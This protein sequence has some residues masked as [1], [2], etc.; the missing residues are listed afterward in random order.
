MSAKDIIFPFSKDV[1]FVGYTPDTPVIYRVSS[2][3]ELAT[4]L[5]R[6]KEETRHTPVNETYLIYASFQGKKI[7]FR[8]EGGHVHPFDIENQSLQELDKLS[9]QEISIPLSEFIHTV[10]RSNQDGYDSGITQG[11]GNSKPE[12]PTSEAPFLE[13]AKYIFNEFRK[14][15]VSKI[16]RE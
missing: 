5:Q 1:D 4:F 8:V 14:L 9:Q 11:Y 2:P 10:L 6:L 13:R 15:F 16:P 7:P 3:K 12:R